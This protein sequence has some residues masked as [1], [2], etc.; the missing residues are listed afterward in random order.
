MSLA[1]RSGS[2]MAAKLP[3]PGIPVQRP[4]LKNRSARSL[5]AGAMSFGKVAK[6]VGTPTRE[7]AGFSAGGRSRGW[8]KARR[9]WGLVDCILWGT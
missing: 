8:S 5:G 1:G 4:T 9:V 6:P 7:P 2:S 3:P